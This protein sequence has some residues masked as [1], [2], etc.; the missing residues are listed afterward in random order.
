MLDKFQRQFEERLNNV[1][2][3]LNVSQLV[4][5]LLGADKSRDACL[6]FATIDVT[7]LLEKMGAI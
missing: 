5:L 7:P 6:Q 1:V 4:A 3:E 2:P